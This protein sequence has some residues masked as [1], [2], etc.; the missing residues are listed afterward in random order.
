MAG[1]VLDGRS[2]LEACVGHTLNICEPCATSLTWERNAELGFHKQAHRGRDRQCYQGGV[3]CG[4]GMSVC[5]GVCLLC[6]SPGLE[7]TGSALTQFQSVSMSLYIPCLPLAT[8]TR[9]QTNYRKGVWGGG[10]CRYWFAAAIRGHS[11][12]TFSSSSLPGSVRARMP[13]LLWVY[14]NCVLEGSPGGL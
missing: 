3:S 9:Q 11:A 5:G 13:T 4:G 10:R 8:Y 7:E 12:P 1:E 6:I 14:L 2:V